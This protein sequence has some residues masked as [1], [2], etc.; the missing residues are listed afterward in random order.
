MQICKTNFVKNFSLLAILTL[1]GAE[2]GGAQLLRVYYPDIE[3][4]SA[5]L[6]VSPTGKSLLVDA[7]TGLKAVDEGIE[8][9]INDLIDAGI[10][11]SLDYIVASHYDEDH[12]G[13]ME[14]VFQLV[15]LAP[16]IVSYDRGEAFSVPSTFA[17][18]DYSFGASLNNR[19]TVA[20]STAAFDLDLGG[21]VTVKFH[22]VNGEVCGGPTVDVTGASQFENNVSVT[23]T[24][25]YGDFD[26]WIGGDLTGNPGLGV[27]D[28]ETPTGLEVLDVDVY[29]VNHHG[30]I[31][32][33][34]ASF[35]GDLAAEVA[36]NQSSI[37]NGFGHPNTEVVNRFLATPTTS[38]G[39]PLFFQQN[40]GDPDDTRSD[41]SLADGIAD[42]DDAA[43]GDVIG[44]PGTIVLL[45]NGTSYR[46]HGCGI[47]ATTL[48]ADEGPGTLGDFPPAI[49]RLLHT[50]RVPLATQSVTVEADLEDVA[51]AEIRYELDGVT[52]T[53]IA[54]SL[55]SGITWT[56]S[57]P[58]QADG[59]QIRFRV[60]ATDASAQ[61]ELSAEGCYFSG[62]TAIS[63][64]RSLDGDNVVLAKTCG[65]R[66]E[67]NMT[68][69]P[70]V[71]H[72]FVTQAWVQ[73]ATGGL[74][75]FDSEIDPAI[76]RGDRVQWIGEV[77][78]FGG[79]AEINTAENFG[80]FGSIRLGA[81]TTPAPQVVTV[82]QVGEATEGE[83]I[84]INGVSVFE[85]TI[86][87]IGSGNLTITDD[88]GTSLLELRIDGD[89]DIPGS[90]T[91]TGTF[92]V[93]GLASQFDSWVPLS[94]GYQILPRGAADLLSD[95]VNFSQVVISEIHADPASGLSGDA[96]GDGSRS[97]TADEFVE[98]L[99]TGFTAVDISGWTLSD[100]S[101]VRHVFA[102]GTVLP[103]REAAVV[104]GGGSPTGSFGNAAANGLVF[105]AS[106]G[107]L[108]LNNSS[109]TVTLDD[110]TGI[111]Q[112]VAYGS[113]A[114]ANQSIVRAP[115]FSNAPFVRHSD[116]AGSG[117]AIYSPGARIDGQAF[118]LRPGDVVLSEVLYDPS[119]SDSGLEWIELYNSTGSPVDLRDLCI[120]AGGTTYTNTLI[121]LD[122]CTGGCVVPAGGTFVLGGPNV[123]ASNSNPSFDLLLQISPG[124]Q[125]SGTTADGVALFNQRCAQ[126]DATS[127]P[128]D[129]V[130]YGVDNSNNLIDETGAANAPDVGDAS[131]GTSI[132]RVD[133]GGNWQIQAT[134]TPNVASLGGN[135]APTVSITAPT[136]GSTVS[137][138]ATVTFMTT[139]NDFEDGDLSAAVTWSSD[140]DGS[141]GTGAS[142]AT[143]S[144]ST[145]THTIT[146]SVIDSGSLGD[147]DTISLT[148]E[149][150]SAAIVLSEVFYDASGS[151]NGLEWV[152]IKNADSA[153]VDLSGYCVGN[154]GTS[155]TYSLV[156]LSG[157]VAAGGVFVV[158]G[159]TSSAAN[160]NPT[161]D[162]ALDFSPDFQNSGS[163]GDGVAL[164]DMPCSSVGSSTVPI[165]AVVY[166]SNNNTGL[167]DETGAA[168]APEV[169]DAPAGSSIERTSLA[170]AWQVQSS[171]TPN[172]SSL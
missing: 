169:A 63:T 110:G 136:S 130:V 118:S 120:G 146:A 38:G 103:A 7:G 56:G 88:G 97:A 89:T 137:V 85:G 143:S 112:Q 5:T 66:V 108:S 140:L 41:D 8:H 80:N 133:L 147:V 40:P 67:G 54:M 44:L 20:C 167:I 27:V 106:S 121:S 2:I 135:S 9:F 102:T 51:S 23:L 158:G 47:P 125:N 157:T 14:N 33:S 75:I 73:D 77:E 65:A 91:P 109:D 90:N 153:S 144:L 24:V 70:G 160:A 58:Q 79:A 4:G 26:L 172:S 164:F 31:T 86:P 116:A 21:G 114:N 101:S 43:A 39:T 19:T 128:M 18:G 156:Q 42:C 45:S 22:T 155:Y 59:A 113:L 74:Q 48:A 148:V 35:L 72:D 68:V 78:Q 131:S 162:Q 145:G 61:T 138:G 37:E 93:I 82:A 50:P 15:P 92:D 60:A 62:T 25:R 151:D 127:V 13:R 132:E 168:N 139:A 12:I 163:T 95:E 159:T 30:S 150:A 84:R 107:G 96:N 161:F 123:S 149:A 17:Y 119:G 71:F 170:G 141:L 3:Q 100:A 105:V 152:E 53:P 57:I 104:F 99:N 94:S 154:G 11:T 83:L 55:S 166:G 52:Q 81:G 29:T 142:V 69:E 122:T 16:G 111:V 115:D 165:D 98:L 171:P 34:N 76:G 1:A 28:V 117:G 126:V 49:R 129:A 32:S 134:P 124:L 64:L 6:V 36:I 46:I 87:E 10:V